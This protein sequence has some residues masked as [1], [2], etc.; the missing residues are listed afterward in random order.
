VGLYDPA[1]LERLSAESED[2]LVTDN[3]VT[4]TKVSIQ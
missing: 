1:T 2:S 3:A 4:L